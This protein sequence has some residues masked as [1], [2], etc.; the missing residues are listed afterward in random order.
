MSL[1]ST[2]TSNDVLI[3]VTKNFILSLFNK[4]VQILDFSIDTLVLVLPYDI[5]DPDTA[6]LVIDLGT[7]CVYSPITTP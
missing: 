4:K 6:V 5:Y 1:E 2:N 7:Y 3:S